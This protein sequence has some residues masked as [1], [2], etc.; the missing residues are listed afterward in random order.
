M[1]RLGWGIVGS[2]GIAL[3]VGL[4]GGCASSNADSVGGAGGTGTTASATSG[5]TSSKAA[6]TGV[7]TSATT[8]VTTSATTSTTTTSVATSTAMSSSSTGSGVP[9]SWTCSPTYYSDGFDCD[10]GCG[11]PDPDCASALVA[12]CGYCDDANSCSPGGCPGSIDPMNNSK[13]VP[14][15][16]ETT[17]ALCADGVDNDFDMAIDCQDTDCQP[18]AACQAPMGWTCANAAYFDTSCDCGCG[19]VDPA[20]ADATSTSCDVCDSMGACGA[21]F[22]SC[23]SAINANNNAICDMPAAE[24]TDAACTDN[25]DNDFDGNTDCDDSECLGHTTCPPVGWTCF[26]YHYN[27]GSCDCGCGVQDIDCPNLLVSSCVDCDWTNSCSASACPGTI[28][29]TNNAVCN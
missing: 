20:C 29:P 1:H 2:A 5:T 11:A 15:Q 28:N 16:P 7:T 3:A 26:A 14:N 25:V 23:F 18:L 17:A 21:S 22:G 24:N 10:C 9:A 6:T 4:A 13:C 19:I 27:N 8:G 12:A